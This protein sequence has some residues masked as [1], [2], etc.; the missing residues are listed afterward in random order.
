[1]NLKTQLIGTNCLQFLP[2]YKLS[3]DHLE[4]FFGSIRAQGGYNNI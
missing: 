1:M 3:Q 2:M 4:I